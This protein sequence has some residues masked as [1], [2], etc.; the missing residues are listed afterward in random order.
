MAGLEL[1][2]FWFVKSEEDKDVVPPAETTKYFKMLSTRYSF[3]EMKKISEI[4][5][6]KNPLPNVMV[7]VAYSTLLFNRPFVFPVSISTCSNIMECGFDGWLASQQSEK[8]M[9]KMTFLVEEAP[10]PRYSFI[11]PIMLNEER[12]VVLVRRWIRD[13]LMFFFT[14]INHPNGDKETNKSM[15]D[16]P[17]EIIASFSG[18]PLWCVGQEAY[19]MNVPQE[20]ISES[21]CV[22]LSIIDGFLMAVSSNPIRAIQSLSSVSETVKV[23]KK[24]TKQVKTRNTLAKL[25]RSMIEEITNTRKWCMPDWLSKLLIIE[26]KE[27]YIMLGKQ[28]TTLFV[29]FFYDMI[30]YL[31][32]KKISY[33]PY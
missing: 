27:D 7:D 2:K 1:A 28:K 14:D 4:P 9:N 32:C 17:P 12:W 3:I 11:F 19:F 22:S 20:N 31:L 8:E 30:C 24:Q 25:S 21:W 15:S 6:A 23:K 16:I 26:D 5:R 18:T 10:N 33:V 29:P 13:S